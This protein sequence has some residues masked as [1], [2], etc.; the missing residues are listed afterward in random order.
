MSSE[1]L[2]HCIERLQ[3]RPRVLTIHQPLDLRAQTSITRLW[4][5]TRFTQQQQS[6]IQ[7]HP[8]HPDYGRGSLW[9]YDLEWTE[10]LD[11]KLKLRIIH[12][13]NHSPSPREAIL[14]ASVSEQP[15][16]FPTS[17][18]VFNATKSRMLGRNRK[19]SA[20]LPALR[21]AVAN[22]QFSTEAGKSWATAWNMQEVV[23]A[24]FD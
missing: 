5:K 18:S 2:H 23:T 3:E 20:V 19:S 14:L 9:P 8:D 17:R 4:S 16:P 1:L 6:I 22:V 10:G 12:N 7:L 24:E 13:P 15:V 21:P 11:A